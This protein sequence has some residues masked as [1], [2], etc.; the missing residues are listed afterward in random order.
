MMKILPGKLIQN[1]DCYLRSLFVIM[2]K[3]TH[4]WF[5]M[6]PPEKK[7]RCVCCQ[8]FWCVFHCISACALYSN[9]NWHY[10]YKA[11]TYAKLATKADFYGGNGV[12]ILAV[13]LYHSSLLLLKDLGKSENLSDQSLAT[14]AKFVCCTI[15]GGKPGKFFKNHFWVLLIVYYFSL[16]QS[17]SFSCFFYQM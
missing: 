11:T 3:L 10:N 13:T 15:Y 12:Y 2:K 14:Y 16:R 6:P 17:F 7:W 4:V 9:C 1:Q 5:T 8:W